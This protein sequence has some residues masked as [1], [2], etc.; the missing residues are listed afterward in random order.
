M[1]TCIHSSRRNNAF[2]RGELMVTVG[3]V[4]LLL[5]LA[6]GLLTLSR[7]TGQR[8]QCRHNLKELTLGFKMWA[9]N[10][11][12]DFPVYYSKE[13]GHRLEYKED[14]SVTAATYF[15]V[16]TN[17]IRQPKLLACP[18]DTRKAAASWIGFT[19]TNLSYFINLEGSETKPNTVFL[20]DRLLTG[21]IPSNLLE[22]KGKG[23][24][25]WTTKHIGP[26]RQPVGNISLSDGSVRSLTSPELTK[27]FT[28]KD[29]TMSRFLFPE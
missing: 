6:T 14:G 22:P 9:G 27:H 19:N 24:F 25:Q 21:D 5:M 23:T 18:A 26:D 29:N 28:N 16:I 15:L 7:S 4:A 12:Q 17:E 11:R 2:T 3:L 20:G 8:D 10:G 1:K 13:K